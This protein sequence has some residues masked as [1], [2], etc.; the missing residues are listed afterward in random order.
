MEPQTFQSP[1]HGHFLPLGTMTLKTD[2]ACLHPRCPDVQGPRPPGPGVEE[3]AA[4]LRPAHMWRQPSL[5]LQAP[6]PPHLQP[7]QLCRRHQQQE[8]TGMS[9]PRC[10]IKN[11]GGT[12][13]SPQWA[14]W[15]PRPDC[16]AEGGAA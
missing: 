13:V 2:G 14:A 4:G 6:R 12:V 8:Q 7:N 11:G 1:E 15:W 5:D 3:P 16:P 10:G 9:M